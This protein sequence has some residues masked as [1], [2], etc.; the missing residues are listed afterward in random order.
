MAAS[1]PFR[2]GDVEFSLD[3]GP[4]VTV[5][6]DESWTIDKQEPM[7]GFGVAVARRKATDELRLE[8]V[9]FPVA[10]IGTDLSVQRL[11]DMADTLQAQLLVDGSGN[12]YGKWLVRNL[13][14]RSGNFTPDGRPRK[15]SWTLTLE[16]ES[17]ET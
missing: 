15:V 17:V 5:E 14:E 11:R 12:V 1:V 2:L 6:R 13:S 3:E 10:E 7:D 16:R 4:L 9:S 8:G